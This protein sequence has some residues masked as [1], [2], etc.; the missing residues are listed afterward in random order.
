METVKAVTIKQKDH[1][2]G[3]ATGLIMFG[4]LVGAAFAPHSSPVASDKCDALQTEVKARDYKLARGNNDDWD[5]YKAWAIA[6][7]EELKGCRIEAPLRLFY[8]D[9]LGHIPTKTQE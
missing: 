3:R 1:M 9:G 6:H 4:L 8:I 2:F 5:A 7:K